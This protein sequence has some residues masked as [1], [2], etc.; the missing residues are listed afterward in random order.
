M[1][2]FLVALF[3]GQ[4]FYNKIN[5]SALKKAMLIILFLSGLLLIVT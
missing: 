3:L 1:P 4:K 5:A 2:F